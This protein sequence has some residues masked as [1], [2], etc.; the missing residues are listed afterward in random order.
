MSYSAEQKHAA[1]INQDKAQG[2]AITS[3]PAVAGIALL[4]PIG[5]LI[6]AGVAAVGAAFGLYALSLNR[7]IRD[8][9]DENFR[10]PVEVEER[11]RFSF[12]ELRESPIGDWAAALVDALESAAALTDASVAS[13]ERAEGAVGANEFQFAESRRNEG[14]TFARSLA[15]QIE[16]GSEL[17]VDP[18]GELPPFRLQFDPSPEKA[19][20]VLGDL[21]APETAALFYRADIPREYVFEPLGRWL[22]PTDPYRSR[23]D[24]PDDFARALVDWAENGLGYANRIR[25]ELKRGQLWTDEGMAAGGGA[26]A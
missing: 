22:D 19:G 4:P 1:E 15:G 9:P 7:V 3:A 20:L 5:P 12:E 26:P 11:R 25:S 13:F 2:V 21:L 10:A 17:S 16:R 6:G 8:P 24:D 18:P 14:L 23:R